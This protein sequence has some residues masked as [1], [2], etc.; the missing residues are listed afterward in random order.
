MALR[1]LMRLRPRRSPA[2]GRSPRRGRPAALGNR[3]GQGAK[4]VV[5]IWFRLKGCA[6]CRGDLALDGGDW[7]CLQCGTY[8]YTGLYRRPTAAR[9]L[10][11]G[12]QDPAVAPGFGLGPAEGNRLGS[13]E[14]GWLAARLP[15]PW[16]T[17]T[18]NSEA[19]TEPAG[20]T[21]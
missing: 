12:R 4:G 11:L 6:K 16:Q 17:A 5:L 18:P 3:G 7:L 2:S 1:P 13:F 20:A 8:Y 14:S 15:P 10:P 21:G 9:R 19:W